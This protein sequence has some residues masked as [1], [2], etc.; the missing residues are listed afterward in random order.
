MVQT[1]FGKDL[2]NI[3]E[4]Q[5]I[6]ALVLCSVVVLLVCLFYHFPNR[7]TSSF[8]MP[9]RIRTPLFVKVGLGNLPKIAVAKRPITPIITFPISVCEQEDTPSLE[10]ICLF[11]H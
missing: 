11:H 4:P 1:L 8:G 10:E 5:I 2:L 9:N 7:K 6:I 3:S